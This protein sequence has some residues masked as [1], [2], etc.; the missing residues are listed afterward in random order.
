MV[1]VPISDLRNWYSELIKKA[2]REPVV[3]TQNGRPVA[4]L[5]RIKEG[6]LETV[7]AQYDPAI[8]NRFKK[9]YKQYQKSTEE[10]EQVRQRIIRRG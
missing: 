3:I 10:K 7:L 2:Q 5:F 4:V 9:E 6:E 1:I 8:R